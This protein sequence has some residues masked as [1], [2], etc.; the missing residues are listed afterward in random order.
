MVLSLVKYNPISINRYDWLE[1]RDGDNDRA[2][3]IGSKICGTV[4]PNDIIS[5][6]NTLF[7]RFHSDNSVRRTGYRVRA[8]IGKNFQFYLYRLLFPVIYFFV[9]L[10]SFNCMLI[11]QIT[12]FNR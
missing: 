7:L 4:A 9:N 11:A 3:L 6:G 10:L 2:P 12:L 1:V 5:S 8:D